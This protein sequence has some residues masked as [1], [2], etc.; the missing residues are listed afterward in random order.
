MDLSRTESVKAGLE[1][2]KK[3]T[4]MFQLGFYESV[5]P[6]LISRV[7]ALTLNLTE[8][9]NIIEGQGLPAVAG[10][11]RAALEEGEG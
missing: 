5:F 11:F 2:A 3:Q 10:I 4:P 6:Y 1:Q 9:A 7:E 8:A